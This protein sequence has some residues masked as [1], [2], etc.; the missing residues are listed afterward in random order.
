MFNYDPRDRENFGTVA[1]RKQ[2]LNAL[3]PELKCSVGSQSR[4]GSSS[5][6]PFREG[7]KGRG[8]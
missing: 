8:V 2:G 4:A 6:P 5:H 7:D 1:G 3:A